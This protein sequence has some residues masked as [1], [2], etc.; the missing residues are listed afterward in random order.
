MVSIF[1]KLTI[2]FFQKTP[3]FFKKTVCI[4]INLGW[5]GGG[6]AGRFVGED[7]DEWM[8]RGGA[9][10][11]IKIIRLQCLDTALNSVV[12]NREWWV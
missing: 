8:E 5:V 6:E 10:K 11:T 9:P 1:P 4:Q 2:F 12:M 3:C 7:L